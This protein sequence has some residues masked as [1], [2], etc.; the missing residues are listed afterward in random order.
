MAVLL[1]EAPS[2]GQGMCYK[3]LTDAVRS[4]ARL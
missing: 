3:K 1:D 2:T 4:I